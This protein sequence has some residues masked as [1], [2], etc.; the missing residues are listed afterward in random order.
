MHRS[1][2]LDETECGT[3][4][5]DDKDDSRIDGVAEKERQDRR[6]GEEDDDRAGELAAQQGQIAGMAI[7]SD[8]IRP[9]HC[10]ATGS[11]AA[12]EPSVCCGCSGGCEGITHATT[13]SSRGC[14]GPRRVQASC[15][16]R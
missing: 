10:E 15:T 6:A 2:L 16:R 7:R 1:P 12:G 13:A 14:D 9:I 8:P 5:D 3:R 4:E 11:F